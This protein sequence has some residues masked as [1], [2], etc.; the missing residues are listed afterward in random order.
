ME[1]N[2]KGKRTRGKGPVMQFRL[3]R[4]VILLDKN[5]ARTTIRYG[6]PEASFKDAATA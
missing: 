3:S 6:S 1:I 4:S 2:S 5:A